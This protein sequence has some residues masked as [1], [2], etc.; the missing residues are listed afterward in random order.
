MGIAVVRGL[1]VLSRL[2]QEQ[3]AIDVEKI[4]TPARKQYLGLG[5]RYLTAAVLAQLDK[6][7]G[8]WR[9]HGPALVRHGFGMGDGQRMEALRP[10]LEA[11]DDDRDETVSTR[12][13][14][15]RSYAEAVRETRVVRRDARSALSTVKDALNER[16]DGDG[17]AL[18]QAAL[19]ETS[20]IKGDESLLKHLKGLQKAMA[21]PGLAPELADRGGPEILADIERVIPELDALLRERAVQTPVTAASELRDILDGLGV[22]LTRAA[23]RAARLAARRLGQPSIEVEFRLTYLTPSRP[24]ETT[25]AEPTEPAEPAKPAEP[26][27]GI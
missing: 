3:M 7:L 25:P 27:T 4:S 13:S 9:R 8:A 22:V 21:H 12:R 6:T 11:A 10:M 20:K 23:Y 19:D 17:V 16:G 15:G 1:S 5:R 18:V 26:T 24:G 14:T 2:E